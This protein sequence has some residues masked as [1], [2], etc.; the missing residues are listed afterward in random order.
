[1]LCITW[2]T[3][4]TGM[5]CPGGD[6]LLGK[7]KQSRG[8]PDSSSR[9][10][11]GAQGHHRLLPRGSERSRGSRCSSCGLPAINTVQTSPIADVARGQVA[12]QA[13]RSSPARLQPLLREV[14][15]GAWVPPAPCASRALPAGA[16]PGPF[17]RTCGH[18]EPRP[19]PGDARDAGG[20][21]GEA[22]SRS[23]ARGF[24]FGD[25]P[26]CNGGILGS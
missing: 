2:H 11:D 18:F 7:L 15:A 16:S 6:I 12:G 25:A 23:P 26:P 17:L 20:N 3:H 24:F 4:G 21:V 14:R 1:M 8:V 5:A 10:R 19:Q 13:G 9:C 22:R